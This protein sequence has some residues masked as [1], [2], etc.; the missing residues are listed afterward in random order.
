MDVRD[1]L[2]VRLQ[3]RLAFDDIGVVRRAAEPAQP[4][5]TVTTKAV[6]PEETGKMS[7]FYSRKKMG[8]GRF[9][10]R[11]TIA[12][13]EGRRTAELLETVGGMQI[14]RGGMRAWVA[15]GRASDVACAFCQ[16]V[17]I[18]ELINPADFSSGARPA[19]YMDVY[20]DGVLHFQYGMRPAQPLFDVNS[21]EPSSLE[22]IEVYSGT[23]QIPAQYNTQLSS[24]C[25][26]LLIWT[27]VPPPPPPSPSLAWRLQATGRGPLP[28]TVSI[29]SWVEIRGPVTYLPQS[30]PCRLNP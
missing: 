1:R 14:K 16:A 26:V 13:W 21:I 17:D 23:A 10:D 7:Q 6:P 8:I 20:L 4:L 11:V 24:G 5:P 18:N 12:K 19:C 29:L 3:L 28:L 22:G 30:V 15:N 9:V 25:G 2:V 27:R